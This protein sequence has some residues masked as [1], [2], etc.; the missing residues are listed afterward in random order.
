MNR[1]AKQLTA[2]FL[3][4]LQA[5]AVRAADEAFDV[6]SEAADAI[7]VAS[8]KPE[9]VFNSVSNVTVIDRDTIERYGYS[10]VS[11]AMENAPGVMIW[12]TYFMQHVPVFRGGL[13]EHYANKILVMINNVPAWNAVTGE[14]DLDRVAIDAVERIELLR[15]PGSVL[16]GSNA[17]TG[18]VNIV[19]R[20]PKRKGETVAAV[21]GG[22]GSGNDGYS[23][24]SGVSRAGG[25]VAREEENAGY[26]FAGHLTAESH[27]AFRWQDEFNI[28][29]T[30]RPRFETRTFNATGRYGRHSFLLNAANSQQAF[31]G[32]TP[33]FSAGARFLHEKEFQLGQY[34][35]ARPD[36]G[37]FKYSF[38]YDRTRRNFPRDGSD[39]MHTD[40]VGVRYVN[41]MTGTVPL[42]EGLDL[43]L[44]GSHDYRKSDHYVI[45]NS[46]SG[47]SSN[48]NEL[49]GRSQWEGS[50][51]AQL[52]YEQGPWRFLAGS[53]FTKNQVSGN[54][55]SSRGSAIF[56]I[57]ERNSVKL[58]AAQAYRAPTLFELYFLTK[59][60]SVG[61]AVGNPNLKAERSDSVEAAYLSVWG[62][63]FANL[64]GYYVRYKDTIQR[65][66]GTFCRPGEP[67]C[68]ASVNFYTNLPA[69][70]A[71]G[72]E[73]ELRYTTP[74]TSAFAALDY[75]QA[76]RGD[77]RSI[78]APAPDT[79][80]LGGG[81]VWNYKYIPRYTF[82]G[83]VSH[84]VPTGWGEFFGSANVNAYSSMQSLRTRLP[85]IGW[86]DLS[87]G[88]KRGAWRH[89][90]AVK[91]ATAGRA[92]VPEYARQ[93]VIE[94][95][96]LLTGRRVE[97][98]S[99]YR[100]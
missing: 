3:I 43:E 25:L 70:E 93:R 69:Y 52:G 65:T 2:I 32:S 10:S 24:A 19:L 51:F 84:S 60:V 87:V 98:T 17:Q 6:M 49:R 23:G 30:I 29:G 79:F 92:Y 46:S 71:K 80:N 1:V 57:N 86:G 97:Y 14:G 15:G 75:V 40:I 63:V 66:F 12:R 94:S 21:V 64:T 91:N 82:S 68:F 73:L 36:W 61:G 90:V 33:A 55:V 4:A 78:P 5:G 20:K 38:A 67:A 58:V 81:E 11:E 99:S 7:T 31:L 83:G 47:A 74:R 22:I 39:A 45:Y 100:F 42:A 27:P 48:E 89:T 54:N 44:G 8:N 88:L 13:Q 85:P 37:N 72:F 26:F 41:N 16:Y 76:N 9:T 28:G 18:V 96:P 77:L 34:A 35:Y 56:E 59:P 50:A 53:R 62:P 95:V